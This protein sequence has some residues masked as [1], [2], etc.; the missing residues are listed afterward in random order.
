MKT[1]WLFSV[2]LLMATPVSAQDEL[3]IWVKAFIPREHPTNP[4]YVLPVPG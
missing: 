3:R 1:F 2:L 4:G